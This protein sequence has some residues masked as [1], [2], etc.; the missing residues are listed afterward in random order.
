MKWKDPVT[1]AIFSI[2][3]IELN[4]IPQFRSVEE[5]TQAMA[6]D[7]ILFQNQALKIR[8]PK[9][10][11]AIPGMSATPTV[12]VPGE[13]THYLVQDSTP[14]SLFR[15][16]VRIYIFGFYLYGPYVKMLPFGGSRL[17]FWAL[18]RPRRLLVWSP[19]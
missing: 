4:R 12:H 10:Y 2:L 17:R 13:S 15:K 7:G 8:R 1:Q 11:Q 5:T 6:F 18:M 19:A 3:G 14:H 9:D 16:G